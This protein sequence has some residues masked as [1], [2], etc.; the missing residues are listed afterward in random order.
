MAT[1]RITRTSEYA[2][3]LRKIRLVLDNKELSLIANG[4][5]KDFEIT[6]GVHT[7]Q[8]KIDWCSSNRLTFTVAESGIKSF[9]LSSFAKKSTLGI[10][11]AIYYI[12]FGAGKYLNIEEKVK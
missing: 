4:E 1:L 12:T 11:S 3:R 8:A 5:T 2:N 10:F 7:L 9:D 6:A